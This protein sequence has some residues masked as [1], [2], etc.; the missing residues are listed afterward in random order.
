MRMPSLVHA[1]DLS[2]QVGE[3]IIVEETFEGLRRV[4]PILGGTIRGERLS[5]TILA[6]GADY[7]IIRSD[8]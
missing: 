6:A 2:V 4:V 5:G 1:A 3:P 7:Q 8:G